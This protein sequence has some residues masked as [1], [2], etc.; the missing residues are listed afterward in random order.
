MKIT[1]SAASN[2]PIYTSPNA[3]TMLTAA[4]PNIS[5][6]VCPSYQ[7]AQLWPDGCTK[8]V[9]GYVCVQ[10]GGRLLNQF[11]QSTPHTPIPIFTTTPSNSHSFLSA[12]NELSIDSQHVFPSV[13]RDWKQ[14]HYASEMAKID[15]ANKL[16]QRIESNRAKLLEIREKKE[17]ADANSILELQVREERA[18]QKLTRSIRNLKQFK[19][20][21]ST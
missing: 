12:F 13:Q 1:L 16:A 8:P 3:R 10:G 20:K 17:T 18:S 11:H 19:A 4:G 21:C 14:F 15:E 9:V 6:D 5:I 7:T 2:T